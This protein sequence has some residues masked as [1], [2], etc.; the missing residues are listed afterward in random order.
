L[1]LAFMRSVGRTAR[2]LVLRSSAALGSEQIGFLD[3]G[4]SVVIIEAVTNQC[5]TVRALVALEAEGDTPVGWVTS[6]KAGVEMVQVGSAVPINGGFFTSAAALYDSSRKPSPERDA[7]RVALMGEMSERYERMN[8]RLERQRSEVAGQSVGGVRSSRSSRSSFRSRSSRRKHVSS[9]PLSPSHGD[10]KDATPTG[11]DVALPEMAAQSP[12]QGGPSQSK[13]EIPKAKAPP[14]I[15]SAMLQSTADELHARAVVEQSMHFDTLPIRM[16]A[17]LASKKKPIDE[18]LREWDR[19]GDGSIDSKEFRVCMR[20]LGGIFKTVPVG[21]IDA[22]FT[23]LDSDHSGDISMGELKTQLN[24]MKAE[25]GARERQTAAAHEKGRRL[26]E[27]AE[28]YRDAAEIRRSLDDLEQATATLENR[29]SLD[30]K[31]GELLRKRTLKIADVLNSWDTDCGGTVD[32]KEF[33]TKIKGLGLPAEPAEMKALFERLDLDGD[34]QLTTAE[35][36]ISFNELMNAAER[37][38]ADAKAGRKR[39]VEISRASKS[40]HE[41]ALAALTELEPTHPGAE[42]DEVDVT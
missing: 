3:R 31:L 41:I 24:R 11:D 2:P 38:K 27:I 17:L 20:N 6:Y 14:P 18:L 10:D 37:A 1:V 36:K 25:A 39:I 40:S 32:V 9:P 23:S 16:V 28:L 7:N 13:R 34:G 29:N 19:N 21:E 8:A 4:A 30:L 42:V 35:I 26:Q 22:M 5:G 33:S 12:D 15:S